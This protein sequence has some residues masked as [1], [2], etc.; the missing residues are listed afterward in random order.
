MTKLDL[1]RDMAEVLA[2]FEA[3]HPDDRAFVERKL[4]QEPVERRLLYNRTLVEFLLEQREK[5]KQT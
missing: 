3:A 4:K 1:K 2:I 5:R